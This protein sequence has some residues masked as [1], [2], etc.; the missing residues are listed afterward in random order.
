[1]TSDP[2]GSLAD[3][4]AKLF[5]AISGQAAE[6]QACDDPVCRRCPWCRW[7]RATSAASPEVRRHLASAATSLAMA[8]KSFLETVPEHTSTPPPIEKIDLTED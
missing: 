5:A 7:A 8:L 3:E 6:S 2:A 4:A 1:M